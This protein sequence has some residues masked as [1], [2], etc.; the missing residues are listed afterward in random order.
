MKKILLVPALLLGTL[1]F[2]QDYNYEVTP[3][4]GYNIAEGN[5]NLDNQVLYGA[6]MQYNGFNSPI[7]PELSILYTDAD[8][9]NS[10]ISTDIYRIALN[11]VYEYGKFGM[12]K[13][14]AKIGFG[15]ETIDKHLADNR[16]GAF[17]N[18]GIGAK[19]PFTDAIALKVESVYMLKNNNSRLNSNLALLA[20]INFAFGPK[21]QPAPAPA[22][23]PKV[24]SEP[25][26]QEVTKAV[27][28]E[29]VMEVKAAEVCPPKINLHINFKFDSAEIE[30]ESVG[31]VNKFA[32]FLKCTPD[33]KAK[34]IG[35]TDSIGS[36]A[37]N[38]KLS[39]KRADAVR[40]MIIKDGVPSDKIT[41]SAKGETEPIATN[42][43][44]EGRA[45]N[46]RIEAEL[47]KN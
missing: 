17:F 9:E 34:I 37:Y 21:A 16:D 40:N 41:T 43:T 14:L 33:Y 23:A 4:I 35:H 24:A 27:A 28:L 44:D 46:R 8:Y 12:I 29:K 45:E 5:L 13:P 1:A 30:Q 32:D 10:T 6:E 7:K 11:G 25:V 18:A 22:P 3:V 19:V 47:T 42:K 38:Q 2:A 36:E 20:G 31:R 15:Y 39:Q 26:K